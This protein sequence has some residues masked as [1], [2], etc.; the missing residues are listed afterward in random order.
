[1]KRSIIS[2]RLAYRELKKSS[3]VTI[4]DSKGWELRVGGKVVKGETF[5]NCLAAWS[6]CH[7]GD[8]HRIEINI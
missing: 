8:Q 1:M 7:F 3:F 2:W 4:K 5:R 6:M